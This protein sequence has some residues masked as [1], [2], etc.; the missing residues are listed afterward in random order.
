MRIQYDRSVH[1]AGAPARRRRISRSPG[2]P[3]RKTSLR[4]P[5]ALL[6]TKP[7]SA[8]AASTLSRVCSVTISGLL[9]TFE[10]VPIATPRDE[11]RLE[12]AVHSARS[13]HHR[14]DGAELATAPFGKAIPRQLSF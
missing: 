9:R 1:V 10:T 12:C 13:G 11:R 5:P 6:R 7:S 2:Q 3:A 4:A 14:C 8:I